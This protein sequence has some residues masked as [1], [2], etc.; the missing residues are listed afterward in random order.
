MSKLFL[1]GVVGAVVIFIWMMLSW[2][3]LPWHKHTFSSFEN[4][5]SVAKVIEQNAPKSGEYVYP[6]FDCKESSC[7]EAK[8][9]MTKGPFIYAQVKKEGMNPYSPHLYIVAFLESFVGAV[10]VSYLL[11]ETRSCVTYQKRICLATMFGLVVGI[12]AAIP[13]WN[14]MGATG[15]NTFIH[16]FDFTVAYFFVGL[17]V[18]NFVKPYP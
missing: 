6:Y 7:T 12:L 13:N 10:F 17:S 2:M 9:A 8:E 18:G 11:K 14:W 5:Q 16:I 3:L 1:G 15:L 4:Q